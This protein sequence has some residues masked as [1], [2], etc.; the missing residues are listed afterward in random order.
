MLYNSGILFDTILLL[1]T[2][3]LNA[4]N[5]QMTLSFI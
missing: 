3:A 1:L 2:L 5:T 4:V